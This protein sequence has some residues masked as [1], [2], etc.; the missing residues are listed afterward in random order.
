MPP[1][2]VAPA[3]SVGFG[4]LLSSARFRE[5]HVPLLHSFLS[6]IRLSFEYIDWYYSQEGLCQFVIERPSHSAGSASVAGFLSNLS[7]AC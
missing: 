5:G 2:M 7:P 6:E 3:T 1:G 4:F